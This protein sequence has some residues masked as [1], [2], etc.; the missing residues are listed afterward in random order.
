M[1]EENERLNTSITNKTQVLEEH[2]T[3]FEEYKVKI[4]QTNNELNGYKTELEEVIVNA[5]CRK[6]RR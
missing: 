6:L 1:K 5:R 4:T 2:K 3:R